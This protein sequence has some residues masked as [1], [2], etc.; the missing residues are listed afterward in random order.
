M[1]SHA[2]SILTLNGT[3]T[4]T[5][6][7]GGPGGGNL[8]LN[9]DAGNGTVILAGLNSYTGSTKLTSGTLTLD[10]SESYSVATTNN[11]IPDTPFIDGGHLVIVSKAP[12]LTQ[13]LN[14]VTLNPGPTS[15][16]LQT[17]SASPGPLLV[18]LGSINRSLGSAVN[19]SN[20]IS[21]TLGVSG[22]TTTT[23]NNASGI[24]GGY[25]T[26]NGTD[27]AVSKGSG[28]VITPFS[29][30]TINTWSPGAEV[31]TSLNTT[32]INATADSLRF[33]TNSTSDV[34]LSG[35]CV[36][37]SGG[38]LVTANVGTAQESIT[39]GTLEGV[40]G[41]DLIVND[42]NT[43]KVFEI[44]SVIA[45][46]TSA[47]ALTQ[48]GNGTLILTGSNTYTGATFIDGGTLQISSNA[49]LGAPAA[50]AALNINGGIFS[51]TAV[52]TLDNGGSN[53]RPV[54]IG[55]SGAT[56]TIGT[57]SLSIPGVISG[58]S[59][60]GI[61]ANGTFSGGTLTLANANTFSGPLFVHNGALLIGNANSAQNMTVSSNSDGAILF[62]PSI[63]QFNFGGLSG[64][65]HLRIWNTAMLP[66][67][68]AVG[69]NNLSTT[70]TGDGNSPAPSSKSA[71]VR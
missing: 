57:S 30:Y 17:S 15:M 22:F 29:N 25:C 6:T 62:A 18:N 20:T 4:Y 12:S 13:S 54:V 41:A 5:G 48:S 53:A 24:I 16:A 71:R 68:V 64:N 70:F 1:P 9:V 10:A 40:A 34:S 43:S 47:T 45:D 61:T 51:N 14:G 7:I 21:A 8:A 63:S 19:L 37:T 65:G 35:T 42:L 31:N 2:Q 11:V 67:T 26:I 38:I 59:V 58:T 52:V 28:S 56:F 27:W 44:D 55:G 36:L 46:N 32:A 49:N 3:G 33:N 23:P 50:G 60:V 39:G 69:A 66:I